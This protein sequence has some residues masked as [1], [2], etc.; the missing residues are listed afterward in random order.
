SGEY[1]IILQTQFIN[2]FLEM[3]SMLAVTDDQQLEFFIQPVIAVQFID[4]FYYKI[5]SFITGDLADES[6]YMTLVQII[7]FNQ[8]SICLKW[9]NRCRIHSILYDSDFRFLYTMRHQILLQ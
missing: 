9:C 5:Q 7:F 4:R 8:F 3:A 2:Q 1:D 6:D